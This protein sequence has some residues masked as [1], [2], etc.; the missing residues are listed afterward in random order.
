MKQFVHQSSI[1]RL[2]LL[3]ANRMGNG[4]LHVKSTGGDSIRASRRIPNTS[5]EPWTVAWVHMLYILRGETKESLRPYPRARVVVLCGLYSGSLCR[6]RS[7]RTCSEM[8]LNP[9]T[10]IRSP[11]VPDHRPPSAFSLMFQP[12]LYYL[13]SPWRAI[14]SARPHFHSPLADGGWI[15]DDT[16]EEIVNL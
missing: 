15:L 8:L 2:F 14:S 6:A 9:T 13:T 12:P 4:N 3:N 16:N 11:Q 7:S 5:E 1:K 10:R